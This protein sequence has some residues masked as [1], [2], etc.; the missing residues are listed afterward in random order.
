MNFGPTKPFDDGSPGSADNFPGMFFLS[1][2]VALVFK[3]VSFPVAPIS[4][5]LLRGEA[6]YLAGAPIE[7]TE[8]EDRQGIGSWFDGSHS[9]EVEEAIWVSPGMVSRWLGYQRAKEKWTPVEQLDR[10]NAVRNE[11]DGKLTFVVRLSSF[12]K[13]DPLEFGDTPP[14]T[15]A[16]VTDV[17]FAVTVSRP[18]RPGEVGKLD[19]RRFE[20]LYGGPI[21]RERNSQFASTYRIDSTATTLTVQ[22]AYEWSDLVGLRWIDYVP[23]GVPLG[24]IPAGHDPTILLGDNYVS[25]FLIQLPVPV[26]LRDVR[27]LKVTVVSPNKQR[28]AEFSLLR[29]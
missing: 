27:E 29:D 13:Q 14:G 19:A 5:E 12:A 3:P 9:R 15:L 10:W 1:A 23:F 22:E 24:G 11:L 18:S 26:G 25:L 4:S 8:I 6:V 28:V 2:A 17:K 21:A 7:K 20:A 16:A